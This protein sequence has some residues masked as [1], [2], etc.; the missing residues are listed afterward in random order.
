VNPQ[1][2]D[3]LKRM[4]VVFANEATNISSKANSIKITLMQCETL[5]KEIFKFPQKQVIRKFLGNYLKDFEAA[6]KGS[7]MLSNEGKKE[8]STFLLKVVW[9]CILAIQPEGKIDLR[10]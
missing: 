1:Q 7:T 8:D 10:K 9:G 5:N 2:A 6:S 3:Q 4:Q